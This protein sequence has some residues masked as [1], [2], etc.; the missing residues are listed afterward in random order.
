MN[1]LQ[2]QNKNLAIVS[3]IVLSLIFGIQKLHQHWDQKKQDQIQRC[4]DC[5]NSQKMCEDFFNG[6]PVE[7][8]DS[9]IN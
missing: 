9:E 7:I 3:A 8:K 5:G 2:Q 6:K 1:Y 4:I